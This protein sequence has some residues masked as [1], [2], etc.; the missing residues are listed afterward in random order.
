ML[1]RIKFQIRNPDHIIEEL[2][3]LGMITQ[4]E[5]LQRIVPR[6]D[7]E[8][9]KSK[10][11]RIIA[12]WILNYHG[13]HNK[14][15][16]L[17]IETICQI[18]TRH[19][20]TLQ[21]EKL[22]NLLSLT[23]DQLDDSFN[24]E[25]VLRKTLEFFK[26]RSL[27][28]AIENTQHFLDK[29]DIEEAELAYY[30][31]KEVVQTIQQNPN[32]LGNEALRLWWEHTD[33]EL[34][35]FSGY[36]GKY[37]SPI[38]RRQILGVLGPPKRGKTTTLTEFT[39]VGLMHK[40]KVAY[41]NLEMSQDKI[42]QRIATRLAGRP[43]IIV[44]NKEFILPVMDCA[45]NQTGSCRL[46][47][48]K[49]KIDL[50]GDDDTIMPYNSNLDGK[51]KPCTV[52]LGRDNYKFAVWYETKE[53][54]KTPMTYFEKVL[55]DFRGI[56]GDNLKIESYPTGTLSVQDL[57]NRLTLM[58]QEENFIPDLIVIDAADNLK[59]QDKDRRIEI[60]RIWEQLTAL[61]QERNCLVVTASQ[62][63]R[64]AVNKPD[65]T[66]EDLAEDFS[67]AMGCDLFLAVNQT[68]QE[69]EQQILRLSII[70][71]RHRG[72]SLHHQCRILQAPEIGQF[73]MGS[74]A[75]HRKLSR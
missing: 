5:F 2:I 46:S 31:Y 61:S 72:F 51:Y 41:F 56:F 42:N 65:L 54:A 49:S 58:E 63:N 1:D 37:L 29:D 22:E 33:E 53:F 10:E 17:E 73:C 39:C 69:K 43:K 34:L 32:P 13:N 19:D 48:R 36:L 40:L 26:R 35:R 24:T 71:H 52:C 62:T 20:K 55:E 59:K 38:C 28:I 70:L 12:S 21:R 16:G 67:K 30:K 14:A 18:E 3:L 45:H 60:G 66:M 25:Y 4:T 6:I 8:F 9:F 7:L 44:K 50:I 64:A 75:A 68:T 47:Y 57:K 27:T 15:P 74:C 11:I 23:L